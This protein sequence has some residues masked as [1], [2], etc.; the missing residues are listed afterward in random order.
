[1][2]E[3]LIGHSGLPSETLMALMIWVPQFTG[4]HFT[5]P[6]VLLPQLYCGPG[7]QVHLTTLCTSY[8]PSI[9]PGRVLPVGNLRSMRR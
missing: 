5:V 7:K 1:M 9:V 4:S 2:N 8:V 3:G 6:G